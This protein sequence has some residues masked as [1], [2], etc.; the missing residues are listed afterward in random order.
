M[1]D[2][3]MLFNETMKYI[4]NNYDNF[5]FFVERDIVWTIQKYMANLISINKLPYEIYNDYPIVKGKQRSKS[6]DLAIVKNGILYKD[7]LDGKQQIEL[8]IEFKYEPS[9]MRKDIC[10]HKLPVV[11]WNKV[12][13]DVDRINNFVTTGTAKNAIA[14][15]IDEYGRYKKTNYK[16]TNI[17]RWIEWGNYNKTEYNV[18]VLWS[19]LIN[20]GH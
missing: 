20:T 12:I 8:A 11:F 19:S 5:N 2:I 17:S 14:I 15:F 16:Y 13:E 10:T 6:V 9:K 18:S 4:E 1:S 7:V 3:L